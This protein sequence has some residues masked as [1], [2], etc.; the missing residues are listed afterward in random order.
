ML[1]AI[2]NWFQDWSD[3]CEYANECAPDFSFIYAFHPNECLQIITVLAFIFLAI[4]EWRI[5]KGR[6]NCAR[7]SNASPPQFTF[8]TIFSNTILGDS[9][10]TIYIMI[11]CS[12]AQLSGFRLLLFPELGALSNEILRKP[13]GVW[14]NAPMM[15]VLTPFFTGLIGTLTTQHLP[16]GI[17]SIL[18][19]VIAGII[20]I[21]LLG[22]PIAPAISAGLLPVT[23]DDTSWWYPF[24]LLVG[25]G[26]LASF[27]ILQRR[28]NFLR[29]DSPASEI[30]LAQHSPAAHC[31]ISWVPF[32]F[33]FLLTAAYAADQTQI[34]FLLFPPLIVIA[35][36]MFAH[37]AVCPW[38]RR[39]L[40][41]PLACGL[42]ASAGVV[43]VGWLGT[44]PVAAGLT[45]FY[46][47]VVLRGLDIHVP[48]AIAVSLL[49][50]VIPNPDYLFAVSVAL[51]ASLL[52]I[53]YSL[54][55]IIR[56]MGQINPH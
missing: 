21:R 30:K 3:A 35:Y 50:F 56:P 14:A 51:G 15:L 7:A 6:H 12:L 43:I 40:V 28:W 9:A 45:V 42:S 13:K 11:I 5:K 16:Y 33:I 52:I 27:S 37:E 1:E 23:L 19:S 39:A 54:W 36:E 10:T 44:G 49:P 20:I 8:K 31:S 34:R 53:V 38:S 47:T 18:I 55:R 17:M 22:S 32:F 24:S 25:T 4:S 29:I 26:L 41:L 2:R 46:A 48:P